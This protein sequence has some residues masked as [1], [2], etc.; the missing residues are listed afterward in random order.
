MSPSGSVALEKRF[1]YDPTPFLHFC[2]YPP[3]E[4]GLTLDLNNLE[5][6]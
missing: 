2:N 4:E 3:F 5:F 1:L 6:P